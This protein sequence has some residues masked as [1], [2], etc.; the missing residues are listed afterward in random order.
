[1]PKHDKSV[2]RPFAA[3]TAS[4]V[5]R[6]RAAARTTG[7][8][9]RSEDHP[10]SFNAEMTT[11]TVKVSAPPAQ[12]RGRPVPWCKSAKGSTT[13]WATGRIFEVFLSRNS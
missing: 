13:Q 2:E 8:W 10:D 6:A 9:P 5:V 12:R 11:T 4:T 1:M 3:T 7:P